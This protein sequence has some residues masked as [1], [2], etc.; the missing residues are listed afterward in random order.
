M[1]PMPGRPVDPA[2]PAASWNADEHIDVGGF[3]QGNSFSR[4]ALARY[5]VGRAVGESVGRTLLVLGVVAVG[6]AVVSTWVLHSTLLAA[7]FVLFAVAVLLIAAVLRA[8]LRRLTAVR[9]YAPLEERLRRLVSDTRRDV[10]RELRRIGLPSHAVTLPLLA[11]RLLGRRR[12]ETMTKLRSFDVERAVPKSRI[13]DV[14][15]VFRNAVGR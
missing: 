9:A 8:L 13:D 10:L 3:E 6:L 4:W 11:V 14:H 2:G 1:E 5:L 15:L 12:G 7:L